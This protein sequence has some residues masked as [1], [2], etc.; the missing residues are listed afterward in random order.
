M[1]ISPSICYEGK[2]FGTDKTNCSLVSSIA[3]SPSALD[4][5]TKEAES[6]C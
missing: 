6:I 1:K 4:L 5:I 2:Q 3:F